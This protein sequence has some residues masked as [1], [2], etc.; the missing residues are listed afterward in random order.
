MPLVVCPKAGCLK[1][2]GIGRE[3]GCPHAMPHVKK[4]EGIIK[5]QLISPCELVCGS[6][7]QDY[8][9]CIPVESASVK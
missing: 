6:N 7:Q 1:C 3:Y 4:P 8:N 5:D 2:C 9:S